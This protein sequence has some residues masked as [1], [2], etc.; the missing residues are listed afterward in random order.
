MNMKFLILA[1]IISAV[2]SNQCPDRKSY[3]QGS[4]TCCAQ[5]GGSYGCCPYS[6][7]TCCTDGYHCCPSGYSC[8]LS[9]G[10]CEAKQNN[11]FL[12]YVSLY[13]TLNPSD[14]I[15]EEVADP[16]PQDL[17]NCL[18]DLIRIAPEIRELVSDIQNHNLRD[19]LK[20]VLELV[21][22]K[23]LVKDCSALLH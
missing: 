1:V 4:A 6:N 21:H 19:L 12:S 20:V 10:T 2:L 16:S 8:N 18:N 9:A 15:K 14:E 23:Q 7:A 11:G 3:C 13:T 22:D 5:P 17:L